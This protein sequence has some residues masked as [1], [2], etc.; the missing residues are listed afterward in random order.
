MVVAE[1]SNAEAEPTEFNEIDENA[2]MLSKHNVNVGPAV[3]AENKT[4]K[5]TAP[6]ENGK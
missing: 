6:I 1:I 4:D 3:V 2:N 5:K